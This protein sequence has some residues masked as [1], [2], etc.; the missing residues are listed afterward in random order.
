MLP[1]SSQFNTWVCPCWVRSQHFGHF[2]EMRQ[3]EASQC[4]PWHPNDIP[5]PSHSTRGCLQSLISEQ[6]VSDLRWQFSNQRP[7]W[8]G[9]GTAYPV[10]FPIGFPIGLLQNASRIQLL[11][12]QEEKIPLLSCSCGLQDLLHL[13]T[14]RVRCPS[15]RSGPHD[16]PGAVAK[17]GTCSIIFQSSASAP[18]TLLHRPIWRKDQRILWNHGWTFLWWSMIVFESNRQLYIPPTMDA[19]HI[20][21][22]VGWLSAA[23]EC[24]A[25]MQ[26]DKPLTPNHPDH[27]ETRSQRGA[28]RCMWTIWCVCMFCSLHGF[29]CI[30]VFSDRQ[31]VHGLERLGTSGPRRLK[32]RGSG[33]GSYFSAQKLADGQSSA[34]HELRIPKKSPRIPG[35]IEDHGFR[36]MESGSSICQSHWWGAKL[37]PR[38]STSNQWSVES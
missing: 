19:S 8:D 21:T 9:V 22:Q 7:V 29:P 6:V 34:I 13:A 20:L 4:L 10:G 1:P 12:L 35:C 17:V 14:S 11:G 2:L 16:S 28:M 18:C 25:T 30:L 36:S 27:P 5:W 38:K 24:A 23:R 26:E 31:F 32:I 3:P 15:G 37:G 33:C